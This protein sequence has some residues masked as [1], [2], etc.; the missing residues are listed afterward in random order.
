MLSV[1]SD[2]SDLSQNYMKYEGLIPSEVFFYREFACFAH[3]G[4]SFL[5]F[6]YP[7]RQTLRCLRLQPAHFLMSANILMIKKEI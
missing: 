7:V 6:A 5:Q 3:A 4:V 2:K 1:K